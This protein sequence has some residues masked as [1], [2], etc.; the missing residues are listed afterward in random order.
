MLYSTRS[1]R[2]AARPRPAPSSLAVREPAR[3]VARAVLLLAI[4]SKPHGRI[5]VESR[6]CLIKGIGANGQAMMYLISMKAVRRIEIV[7]KLRGVDTCSSPAPHVSHVRPSIKLTESHSPYPETS[8]LQILIPPGPHSQPVISSLRRWLQ[9]LGEEYVVN[10]T[11]R[12]DHRT[13][14]EQSEMCHA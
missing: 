4:L 5:V 2:R 13:S 8:G 14:R 7:C 1:L 3:Q 10:G 9:S 6:G 12:K 11:T